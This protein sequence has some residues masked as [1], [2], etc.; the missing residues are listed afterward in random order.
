M[1][2][3]KNDNNAFAHYNMAIEYINRGE[4]IIGIEKLYF[5]G[6]MY[7]K[8]KE[9]NKVVQVINELLTMQ[10]EGFNVEKELKSLKDKIDSVFVEA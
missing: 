5:V 7:F 6:K 1:G 2:I 4:S 10:E 3:D 9:Y 8:M